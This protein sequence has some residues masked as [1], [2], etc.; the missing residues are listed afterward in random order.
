MIVTSSRC[1]RRAE[2]PSDVAHASCPCGKEDRELRRQA[3]SP[4]RGKSRS[5]RPEPYDRAPCRVD[6]AADGTRH[7]VV[8]STGFSP[9]WTRMSLRGTEAASANSKEVAVT[10]WPGLLPPGRAKPDL[11]A[12]TFALDNQEQAPPV[13]VF[14]SCS[15]EDRTWEEW[16]S[17]TLSRDGYSVLNAGLFRGSRSPFAGLSALKR[18]PL[19]LVVVSPH[20]FARLTLIESGKRRGPKTPILHHTELRHSQ[21]RLRSHLDYWRQP[22]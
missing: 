8:S 11:P 14:I 7:A 15:V 5:A 6:F 10:D 17:W 4:T 20:T 19:F 21:S 2:Q 22:R 16:I 18:P 12:T 3:G 1:V 9:Q 13:D